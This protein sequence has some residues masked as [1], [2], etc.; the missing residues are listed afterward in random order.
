MDVILSR[1]LVLCQPSCF[2]GRDLFQ[3]HGWSE[4]AIVRIR[5]TDHQPQ[6]ADHLRV[7]K[8]GCIQRDWLGQSGSAQCNAAAQR[9][10]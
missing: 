1:Q 7:P 2:I 9:G 6:C 4:H 3:S 10:S 5:H 8:Q